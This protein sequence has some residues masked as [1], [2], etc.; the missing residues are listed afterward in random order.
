MENMM[1]VALANQGQPFGND[2]AADLPGFLRGLSWDVEGY[3]L[4]RDRQNSTSRAPS[5]R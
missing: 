4:R 3:Q 5:G 2:I 1:P